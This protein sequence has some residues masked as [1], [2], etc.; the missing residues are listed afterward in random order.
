MVPGRYAFHGGSAAFYWDQSLLSSLNSLLDPEWMRDFLIAALAGGD[1]STNLFV[2]MLN[3]K[4]SGGYWYAFNT[5]SV[6][7]MLEGYLGV[8]N[9][10]AFLETLV[11]DKTI[12]EWMEYLSLLWT[13]PKWAAQEGGK[14]PWL[15]DYGGNPSN[16]LECIPTYTHT[17][18]ALQAQNARMLRVVAELH[19]A[20]GN[21]TAAAERRRQ[22]AA[23]A[24]AVEQRLYVKGKGY[25]GTLQPNGTVLA[26]RTC[27]DFMYVTDAISEQLLPTTKSEMEAFFERE[28]QRDHWMVA[29][30][31]HDPIA[32]DPNTRRDD[33][34]WTGAYNAWP[35]LSFEA[36][37]KLGKGS[38]AGLA[39]AMTFLISTATVTHNGPYVST[40]FR[41]HLHR[42]LGDLT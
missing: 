42:S 38:D 18:A 13:D 16:F 6:F 28:L 40:P 32:S 8:T 30:S 24:A 29:L 7:W 14:H 3:T 25:F 36:L 15:A 37:A 21:H 22:A 27:L 23:I 5:I 11:G 33:H 35:A 2:E 17:V 1:F 10:S 20:A 4:P 9:D 26:V 39:K 41:S 34:G 31:P 19:E 12:A